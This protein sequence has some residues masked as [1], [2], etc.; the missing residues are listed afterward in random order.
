M[1]KIRATF[2]ALPTTGF[3]PG[4]FGPTS[5]YGFNITLGNTYDIYMLGSSDWYL[6]DDAGQLEMSVLSSTQFT[7]LGTSPCWTIVSIEIPSGIQISG[8]GTQ[9]YP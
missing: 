1:F 3:P 8:S 6:I 4:S 5:P 7:I 2:S 9:I